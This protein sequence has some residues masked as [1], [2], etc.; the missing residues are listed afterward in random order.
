M[1]RER[2]TLKV[3]FK[4]IYYVLYTLCDRYNNFE[5]HSLFSYYLDLTYKFRRLE[6]N[7]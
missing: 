4:C 6:Q 3:L 5:I 1:N 7:G 2:E